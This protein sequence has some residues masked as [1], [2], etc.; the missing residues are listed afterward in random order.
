MGIR[1]LGVSVMFA[2]TRGMTMPRACPDRA[3]SIS[4][5]K[6]DRVCTVVHAQ[7]RSIYRVLRSLGPGSQGETAY[8][9]FLLISGITSKGK[10][11][12]VQTRF[13]PVSRRRGAYPIA[14]Q[15]SESGAPLRHGEVQ[16]SQDPASC[17]KTGHAKVSD[18]RASSPVI[19]WTRLL[20]DWPGG[21]INAVGDGSPVQSSSQKYFCSRLTQ[22]T[23]ISVAVPLPR[24]AYRDRHGRGAGCG[25]RGSVGRA[26]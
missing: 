25:G 3:T 26:I 15:M 23:S 14:R 9:P 11:L 20:P 10:S 1:L 17:Q 21:Q 12:R 7:I 4:C 2:A 24:G 8:S 19:C 22:I 6:I 5:E 13:T 18:E 16:D